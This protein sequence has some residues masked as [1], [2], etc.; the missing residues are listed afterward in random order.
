MGYG[1]KIGGRAIIKKVYKP[2]LSTYEYTFDVASH[3][4][5]VIGF[6]SEA[7]TKTGSESGTNAGSYQ[8]TFT[9]ANGYKWSDGSKA[10]YTI[11]WRI[12]K[13]PIDIPTVSGD[14]VFVGGTTR[15]AN[16]NGNDDTYINTSGT[17][18]SASF[19]S[20]AYTVSFALKYHDDTYWNVSG[21]PTGIQNG[22]WFVRWVNG[23][24]HYSNDVFNTG[25]GLENIEILSGAADINADG[26]I[27]PT[28]SS[29]C[30]VATVSGTYN[31][32][33]YATAEVTRDTRGTIDFVLV[34][35][36]GG[37]YRNKYRQTVDPGRYTMAA[38]IDDYE[39]L[40]VGF[41]SYG[42]KIW[43][44]TRN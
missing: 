41:V 36:T 28:N 22:Y 1:L 15:N 29:F 3:N 40:N 14:Y 34:S 39:K 21:Q 31:Y 23:Q 9:L 19:S 5:S 44:I 33:D 2:T 20:S 13:R 27:S 24:S 42:Q 4:P 7:M 16:I 37:S 17:T 11:T 43:R 26:S 10:P 25:W 35:Y 6:D 18:S 38:T 32:G 30:S 12:V 8:I